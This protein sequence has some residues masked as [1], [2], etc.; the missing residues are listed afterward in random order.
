VTS[1]L[2]EVGG[3]TAVLSESGLDRHWRNARTI[4]SHNPAIFRQAAIGDYLLNGTEPETD[5]RA[6]DPAELAR[7]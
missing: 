7:T 5:F 4:A 3:A 1:R 6:V 2:F